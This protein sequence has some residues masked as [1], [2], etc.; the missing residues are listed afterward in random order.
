LGAGD[1]NLYRYV[2][3][4]PLNYTDPSGELGLLAIAALTVAGLIIADAVAPDGVQAPMDPC[5]ILPGMDNSHK[6]A[7]IEFLVGAGVDAA[8]N[9]RLWQS[10]GR[11]ADDVIRGADNF[12][13]P[14]G[15]DLVPVPVGPPVPRS[16]GNFP[17]RGALDDVFGGP[18]ARTGAGSAAA[19]SLSP[20]LMQSNGGS[21]VQNN[22]GWRTP[23]GKYASPPDGSSAGRSGGSAEDSVLDRR[24]LSKNH[25]RFDI[26]GNSREPDGVAAQD[27]NTRKPTHIVEVKSGQDISLTEQI[28]DYRDLVG[29]DGTLDIYIRRNANVT[30]P[31]RRA[32]A[33]PDNPINLRYIDD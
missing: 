1:A 7:A 10:A 21:N 19:E 18:A 22:N 32:N 15:P 33:D 2:F 29:Q 13:P 16:P 8:F 25:E 23:D 6:R 20:S 9:P 3:N 12:L 14:S 17:G 28:R 5:N 30:G 4:S 31:V 24:G 26:N 27:I 11:F